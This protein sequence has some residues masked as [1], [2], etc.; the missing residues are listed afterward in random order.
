M[1]ISRI[2]TL[3]THIWETR[4]WHIFHSPTKQWFNRFLL[5][6]FI[7]GRP[8][9]GRSISQLSAHFTDSYS[10]SSYLDNQV[11]VDPPFSPYLKWQFHRF[12]LWELIFVRPGLGRSPPLSVSQMTIS[13]IA[14]L[15]AYVWQAR[16]WWIY[17][18]LTQGFHRFP[19]LRAHIWQTSVLQIYPL[20]WQFLRSLIWELIFSRVGLGRSTLSNGNF[21]DSYSDSSYLPD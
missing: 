13:Q 5:W 21:K 18:R 12:L 6:E 1:K 4:S 19:T 10:E 11:L 14:T 16:S 8:G 3:R 17:P 2:P 20:K 7:F 15:R 9:L